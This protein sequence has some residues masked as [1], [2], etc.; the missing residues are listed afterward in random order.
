MRSEWAEPWQH[1]GLRTFGFYPDR[2]CSNLKARRNYTIYSAVMPRF[3]EQL[4]SC[5][6]ARK[7]RILTPRGIDPQLPEGSG[8]AHLS[9]R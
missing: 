6:S 4:Q 7:V 8:L 9:S 3:Y 1:A 2:S 5:I